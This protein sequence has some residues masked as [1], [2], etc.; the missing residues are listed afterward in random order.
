MD[1]L[2]QQKKLTTVAIAGEPGLQEEGT[3]LHCAS[4]KSSAWGW[5][6]AYKQTSRTKLC[7]REV[8]TPLPS[9]NGAPVRADMSRSE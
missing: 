9:L 8:G 2:A 3:L 1:E 4:G 7:R 5:G 6:L